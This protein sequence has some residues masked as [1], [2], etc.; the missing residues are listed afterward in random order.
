[1]DEKMAIDDLIK[2]LDSG[3]ANGVGH[4]NVN[5]EDT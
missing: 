3:M 4:V 1:M 5:C 2:M